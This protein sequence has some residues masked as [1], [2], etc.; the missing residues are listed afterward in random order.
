MPSAAGSCGLARAA[1]SDDGDKSGL[2]GGKEHVLADIA[3]LVG[4]VYILAGLYVV[5][6]GRFGQTK[7]LA[8]LLGQNL[9]VRVLPCCG[10]LF[11]WPLR[12]VGYAQGLQAGGD[13]R[14]QRRTVG[15]FGIFAVANEAVDDGYAVGL[16]VGAQ[17]TGGE[18]RL[19][20]VV[21]GHFVDTSL[22]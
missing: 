20:D 10:L 13:L 1:L 19:A 21:R 17:D 12:G 9:H 22:N 18:L 14:L 16:A 8:G 11:G 6:K 4:E 2:L 3:L 5:H 15:G 7:G